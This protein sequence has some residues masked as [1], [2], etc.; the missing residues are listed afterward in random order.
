[1]AENTVAE[2]LWKYNAL[3]NALKWRGLRVIEGGRRRD[4][5]GARPGAGKFEMVEGGMSG[6]EKIRIDG[7]RLGTQFCY[8]VCVFWEFFELQKLD[9]E[10]FCVAYLDSEGRLLDKRVGLERVR[11]YETL[12][13]AHQGGVRT[14]LVIHNRPTGDPAPKGADLR[15]QE[16]LV[17][18]SRKT[19]VRFDHVIIGWRRFYSFSGKKVET[20]G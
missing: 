19:G 6:G 18:S 13:R 3:K 16:R 10:V 20:I 8:P 17:R 4:R 11:P 15:L 5:P 9:R 2:D 12:L 1:M 14:I 7:A